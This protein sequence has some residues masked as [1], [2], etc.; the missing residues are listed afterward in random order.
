MSTL[1]EKPIVWP[2]IYPQAI[3]ISTMKEVRKSFESGYDRD[4]NWLFV[5]V[6]PLYGSRLN[7]DQIEEILA[8]ES[9]Y[10]DSVNGRYFA[11]VLIIHPRVPV[12][13]YGD[14]QVSLEDVEWLRGIVRTT[15]EAINE[16]QERNV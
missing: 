5:G 11:T 1:D 16:S 15:L 9:E 10:S 14:I 12:V 3:E 2:H 13:K 6:S 7:L 8:D 4:L